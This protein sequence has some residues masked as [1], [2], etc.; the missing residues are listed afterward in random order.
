MFLTL[1]KY[2]GATEVSGSV[3]HML[4]VFLNQDLNADVSLTF[5][6]KQIRF[7]EASDTVLAEGKKPGYAPSKK[8]LILHGLSA[9]KRKRRLNLPIMIFSCSAWFTSFRDLSRT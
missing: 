1:S 8:T 9:C 3:E 7:K 2:L 4:S 5:K 6:I